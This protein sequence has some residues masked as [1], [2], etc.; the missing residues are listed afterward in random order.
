MCVCADWFEPLLVAHTTLLEI[1]C[2]GSFKPR[3]AS[4]VIFFDGGYVVVDAVFIV[5]PVV[6][7]SFVFWYL[8]AVE[9]R[10]REL[11]TFYVSCCCCVAVLVTLY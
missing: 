7:G 4:A 6:Y 5:E 3:V 1:T 9:E 11:V 10:K 8:F 2:R